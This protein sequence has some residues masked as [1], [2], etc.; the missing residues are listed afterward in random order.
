MAEYRIYSIMNNNIE[1]LEA[2]GGLGNPTPKESI[3][4][5][6]K[7]VPIEHT[8]SIA[9]NVST[10]F[11]IPLKVY[12]KDGSLSKRIIKRKFDD[13][14]IKQQKA[15]LLDYVC[16]TITPYFTKSVIVFGVTERGNVHVHALAYSPNCITPFD[17]QCYRSRLCSTLEVINILGGRDISKRLMHL[18]FCCYNKYDLNESVD[19]LIKNDKEHDSKLGIYFQKEEME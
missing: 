16:H 4:D 3:L 13:L 2:E 5:H 9:I 7:H 19:Y 11:K 12:N 1:R 10:N 14:E 17:L 6:F 18:H 15:F 8:V